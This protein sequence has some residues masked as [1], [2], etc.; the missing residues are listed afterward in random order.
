MLSLNTTTD[1]LL[2]LGLQGMAAALVKQHTEPESL[3]LPFEHR[4]G[5]LLDEEISTRDNRRIS[6]LLKGAKLRYN[7]AA[8]EDVDYRSSR[9]LDRLQL[10]TLG[11]GD[12]MRHNQ[13]LILTGPTGTGKSWLACAFGQQACRQGIATYYSTATHLFEELN[14][15]ILDGTLSK[16]RRQLSNIP[17]LIIDDLGIGGIDPKIGPILLEILDRQSMEGALIITSQYPP[18]KWYDLFGDPTIADA[19]LDRV[20][21]RAHQIALK[22]ESMRKLKAKKAGA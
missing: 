13:N 5:L 9:G 7:Q 19:I 1:K 14:I 8:L 20:V 4:L 2:S 18:E 21:H 16:K 10:Q 11:T 22:G 15:G 12:W 17:L 3:T 6:R